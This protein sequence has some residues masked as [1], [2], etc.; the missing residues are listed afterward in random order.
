M[1]QKAE[2]STCHATNLLKSLSHNAE[3]SRLKLIEDENKGRP[4]TDMVQGLCRFLFVRSVEEY[5]SIPPASTK[6]EQ[7]L[8]AFPQSPPNLADLVNRV[9]SISVKQSTKCMFCRNVDS[10]KEQ[11]H[12]TELLYPS[13]NRPAP[14]GGKAPRTTF[15]QVL[16]MSVEREMVQKGWCKTCQRYQNVQVRRTI[17]STVPAVLA[18]SAAINTP[19]I[20]RL[21]AT[22]GWLPE[23]I[24]IIVNQNQFFCYEGQDLRLHLQRGGMPSILITMPTN[25]YTVMLWMP[26]CRKQMAPLQRLFGSLGLCHRGAHIQHVVEDA[27][28]HY[29]PSQGGK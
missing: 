21:W 20:R 10:K 18:L 2:G 23:E 16:K 26:R 4:L 8:F 6:L 13:S 25:E 29:V 19:E 9:M 7:S 12:V 15:S 27:L 5:K 11:S 17:D 24:G 14:R 22:P 3:A 28:C 1:M